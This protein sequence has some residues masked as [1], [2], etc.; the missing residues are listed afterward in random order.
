MLPE[1]SRFGMRGAIA[2]NL[3]VLLPLLHAILLRFMSRDLFYQSVQEDEYLEWATFWAFLIAAAVFVVGAVRQRRTSG[4]IP[5]FLIGVGLFCFAF[6][7]EEISWGQRWFAYRPPAYFLEHNF[8]QELNVHNVFST[9]LR[10]LT[11]KAII[12]GYG[13]LLPLVPLV[14]QLRRPLAAGGIVTPPLAVIPAFAVTF[15]TYQI[16]PWSFAGEIV[17]LMLGLGFLAAGIYSAARLADEEGASRTSRG[18]AVLAIAFYISMGLGF[19]T[20]AGSRLVR[21]EDP[22]NIRA[23]KIESSALRRDFQRMALRNKGRPVTRCGLHKRV[24][25]YAVDYEK[26]DLL[27]SNL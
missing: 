1:S 14:P 11:L 23:A 17:E 27:D 22:A 24:Y 15:A 21:S 16:Y 19:A 2:A 7:M 9:S 6:A 3:M 13:V 25:T 18:W 12:L 5:W 20:A 10:K 26:D 8:Q 4:Q